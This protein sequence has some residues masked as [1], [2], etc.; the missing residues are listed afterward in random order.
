MYLMAVLLL[1]GFVCNLLVRPVAA[2]HYSTPKPGQPAEKPDERPAPAAAS[3]AGRPQDMR[4]GTGS[5][6][7]PLVVAWTIVGVP[8][9]WGV[10]Q[11]I[12]K[13]LSL[14]R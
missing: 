10:W 6:L 11:V 12:V 7:I 8:L 1:V 14:F 13:S 5:A 9:A 4:E 2:R 3:A